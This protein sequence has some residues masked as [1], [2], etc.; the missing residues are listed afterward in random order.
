MKKIYKGNWLFKLKS[1]AMLCSMLFAGTAMAQLS[2][3]YTINSASATSGTNFASFTAFASAINANGVSANVTVDVVSG[4]GPY[5]GQLALT[6]SGTS[7]KT[8]TINGNGET[9]KSSSR[10]VVNLNGADYVTIDDMVLEAAGT[11]SGTRGV[12]FHAGADYN[13]ISNCEIIFSAYTG[14]SNSTAYISFSNSA[15]SSSATGNHGKKNVITDNVMR[16]STNSRGPYYGYVDY[17]NGSQA[18]Q[19]VANVFTKNEVRDVYFYS[20]YMR[21]TNGMTIDDNKFHT[22]RSGAGNTYWC[23]AYYCQTTTDQISIS[24]NEYTNISGRY[25]YVSYIYRTQGTAT[26]PFLYNDNKVYDN[27]AEYYF[28]GNR[29]YYADYSECNGNEMTGNTAEYYI[30]YAFMNLYNNNSEMLNNIYHNNEGGYGEMYSIYCGNAN[31][32]KVAH[33]TIALNDVTGGYFYYSWY[34][35]T[36]STNNFSFNNNILTCYTN[37]G[38]GYAYPIRWNDGANTTYYGNVVNLGTGTYTKYFYKNNT[39]YT[40][41]AAWQAEWDDG[42]ITWA[43]PKYNDLSSGDLKPT[44]PVISNIGALNMADKDFAGVS[45]TACGPDPGAFEFYVDHNVSNLDFTHSSSECGGFTA[46]ISIDFTNGTAVDMTDVSLFYDINGV[47]TMDVMASVDANSTKTHDFAVDPVFN[48]PGLNTVTVGLA[49]D[50]NTANNTITTSFTV[51]PSPSGADLVQGSTWDGYFN[52]GN[53]ADPDATV[54]DY[55]VQYDVEAPTKYSASGAFGTDWTI[56]NASMTAGGMDVGTTEGLTITGQTISFDPDASLADSLIYVSVVINDV[57]TGCDST[58]GRYLYVPH[59]PVVSFDASDICLGDVAQFKNTSTLG[60]TDYMLNTWEFGDPDASITDDNSDIKDGFWNYSTYGSATVTLEVVNGEYPLFKYSVT[61]TITVTPKPELD[62]KVLNACEQSPIQF[63]NSSSLPV[64][65]TIAYEWDFNGEGSSIVESPSFTFNTPGQ[66]VV[67]LTGTA[68]GC[69]ATLSKNAYQF[70]MPTANF[71]TNGACNFV[72]V[73]FVNTSTI[74]NDANMGFAWDFGDGGISRLDNAAHAFATSGSKTVTL[75]A[76]SEFG[77]VSVKNG[78]VTLNESPE[79][80]FTWDAACNLTPVSFTRTGSVPNGG[81]N[82]SYAW[83]FNGESTSAMENPQYLFP[84]V[85]SKT[86]TLT[87]ADLNGCSSSITKELD[88]VL[89]AVADFEVA[90]VCEGDEAVFTNKSAVAAGDLQYEWDFNDNGATS[91]DLS[92]R[93]AYPVTGSTQ[94]ISV[95]LKAIVPGGCS[96]EISKQ[97]TVNAA[98]DASFT[99]DR[100]GRTVSFDAAAGNSLYQWRFGD[101]ASD[102][103]EDPVYTYENVDNG[104][105][106]VCLATKNAE[107]WSESCQTITINLAGVEDLTLNNDMINVYP[108][109]TNG[110]FNLEVENASD[111]TI[112]VADILG[113][114][115]P[116]QVIDNL[117]GKYNVNMSAIADGVYF[118]QVKNGNYY[119]TKRI[120]VAK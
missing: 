55:E 111:V 45:R 58:I 67:T 54:A 114:I 117:N 103:S 40:S 20:V 93:H 74:P 37:P 11:S 65:G 97:L 22:S 104:T 62:F 102:D 12:W 91:S 32:T 77:C 48:T 26:L 18:S 116:T 82:S 90:D 34:V 71:T 100:K 108:N 56:T 109:P 50:D 10:S 5:T 75:T 83:D 115:I 107:C 99:V 85:G 21:Y 52:T 16:G 41:F 95:T 89:Q 87:V 53:M 101:G 96:D 113:N 2:G 1:I 44:N 118:V 9:L 92:P 59:T 78:T 120:T 94:I 31:N 66:R 33:N 35:Q 15:T 63:N 81:A 29:M 25:V 14:T 3:N 51:N 17:R 38:Y 6:V 7:A 72:D 86:V 70:E 43:D 61:K 36:N 47:K 98:P 106:E 73:E 39:N 69:A 13:T 27:E 49:C 8:I 68:N 60:G 24:R 19:T 80:D 105:F 28:Y 42:A 112:V 84:K 119:A 4:S 88:V 64:T 79:A 110:Q 76:T 46:P 57:N 23:Y 30:Y